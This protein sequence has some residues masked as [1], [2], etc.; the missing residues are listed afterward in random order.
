MS[1]LQLARRASIAR[2][3]T[4][5]RT[6]SSAPVAASYAGGVAAPAGT[7]WDFVTFN[8]QRVTAATSRSAAEPVVT[9]VRM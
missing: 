2:R 8:G 6:A 1:R 5:D 7:R 3:A 4:L 9:L